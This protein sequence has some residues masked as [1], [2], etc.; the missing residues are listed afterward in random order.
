MKKSLF[1][2]NTIKDNE[3]LMTPESKRLS[4]STYY[5]QFSEKVKMDDSHGS[6]E[7][8]S[9]NLSNFF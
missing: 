1:A 4:K 2:E 3:R 6:Q 8:K 5:G 7:L 9:F